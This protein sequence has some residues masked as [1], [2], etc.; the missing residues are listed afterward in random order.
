[1]LG[2]FTNETRLPFNRIRI[3]VLSRSRIKHVT[4]Q[5]L[6]SRQLI[7]LQQRLQFHRI[8]DLNK[9]ERTPE[10]LLQRIILRPRD[11]L[12]YPPEALTSKLFNIFIVA[13]NQYEATLS[14]V[15]FVQ[16]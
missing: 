9:R 2:A 16:R 7:P 8:A 3:E 13:L 1:M 5:V 11:P 4:R 15:H 12:D 14:A 10:A 6:I